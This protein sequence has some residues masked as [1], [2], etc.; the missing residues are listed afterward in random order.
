MQLLAGHEHVVQRVLVVDNE[1]LEKRICGAFGIPYSADAATASVSAATASVGAGAEAKA[2]DA[3][4]DADEGLPEGVPL[5]PGRFLFSCSRVKTLRLWDRHSAQ[6]LHVC[7]LGNWVSDVVIH[8]NNKYIVVS[9]DDKHVRV[10]D[11]CRR[12]REVS[13]V[14]TNGFAGALAYCRGLDLLGVALS[15]NSVSVLKCEDVVEN[16][17]K[18]K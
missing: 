16:L 15:D 7:E 14:K 12:L 18:N 1:T 17:L 3:S 5:L 13:K 4:A 2:A 9:C 8:P 11:V 10:L 6:C